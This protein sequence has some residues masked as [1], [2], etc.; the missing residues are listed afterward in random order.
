MSRNLRS[1]VK[2]IARRLRPA[3]TGKFVVVYV[4]GDENP[5]DRLTDEQRARLGAGDRLIV[6][7]Y[8]EQE[9]PAHA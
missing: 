1:E 8:V 2:A 6:V 3:G 9:V 5:R 4:H 7:R